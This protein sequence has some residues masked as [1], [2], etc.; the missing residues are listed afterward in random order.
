M[1]FKRDYLPVYRTNMW[2]LFIL[3]C[4]ATLSLLLIKKSF[5]E[6]ETAAFEVL[7]MDGNAGILQFINTLQYLSIP[8][9]YIFKFAMTAFLLWTGAFLFGYRLSYKEAFQT[10]IIAEFIFL[11]PELLKILYFLFIVNDP[12]LFEVQSFYPLSLINFA[13]PETLPKKW[14]YPMKAANVF[15]V[16]YWFILAYLLHSI[17][18]K[19]KLIAALIV[20]VAYVVPFIGWLF[21]YTGIY[22]G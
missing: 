9:I 6:S 2:G 17:F 21:Y 10:V 4:F 7:E 5:I 13:D 19:K 14:F 3:L 20:L 8:V 18:R 22:K 11:I 15:E 16:L 12:S 1:F